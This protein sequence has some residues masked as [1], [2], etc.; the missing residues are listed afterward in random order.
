MIVSKII[1]HSDASSTTIK[2]QINLE[3]IKYEHT[4]RIRLPLPN[5]MTMVDEKDTGPFEISEEVYRALHPIEQIMAQALQRVGK[6]KIL[7]QDPRF[8]DL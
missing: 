7:Y 2:T 8:K 4:I 3:T 5:Q 6:V 1:L